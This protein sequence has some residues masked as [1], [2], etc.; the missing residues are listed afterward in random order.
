ME[1]HRLRADGRLMFMA[2]FKQEQIARVAR[3]TLGHVRE[4]ETNYGLLRTPR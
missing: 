4:I 3:Q 2:E 1:L